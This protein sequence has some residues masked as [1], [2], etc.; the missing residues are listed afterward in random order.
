VAYVVGILCSGRAHG[1][2]ASL[3]TEML[4]GAA[5]ISGV[6]VELVHLHRHRFG[7]CTS[8][9]SCVKK[10][11][12]GCVLPDDMGRKGAAP[13]FDK[14][15][16]A[17]GLMIADPVHGWGPSSGAH[18][19]VERLYPFVWTGELVGM[20]FASVSC[21]SNQGF[22]RYARRELCKW[23][24]CEGFRYVGGLAVHCTQLKQML[25]EARDLGRRLGEAALVDATEGRR[26]FASDVERYEHYADKPWSVVEPYLENLTEGTMSYD[27]SLVRL[28]LEGRAFETDEGRENLEKAKPY[29]VAALAEYRAGNADEAIRNLEHASAYWTT[30]TWKE[31]LEATVIGASQPEA[32]RPLPNEDEGKE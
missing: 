12:S 23:A 26:K 17:S 32:Y 29:L 5:S 16:R 13:L 2:T 14:V 6:S 28:G 7:P 11:G 31:F 19:F 25:S 22:H 15:R 3:M 30:A 21:A 9:F 10:P 8:C 20:P 1:Y 24:F 27:G 18:L 4:E